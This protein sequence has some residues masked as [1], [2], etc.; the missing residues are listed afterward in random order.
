MG[1]NV[2]SDT[3][4]LEEKLTSGSDYDN[5]SQ[6]ASA[7]QSEARKLCSDLDE[8]ISVS[9]ESIN[10]TRMNLKYDAQGDEE[11]DCVIVATENSL[12]TIDNEITKGI[13][14]TFLDSLKDRR[15]QFSD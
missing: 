14:Q 8:T 1:I 9:A 12:N 11:L 2:D 5:L 4:G 13:I 10:N 15:N 6:I 7:I 3:T